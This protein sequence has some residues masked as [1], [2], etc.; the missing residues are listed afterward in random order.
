MGLNRGVHPLVPSHGS[1]GAS[2]DLAPLAHIALVLIGEGQVISERVI[3][4]DWFDRRI[5]QARTGASA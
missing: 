2:G 4:P 5:A 3:D 1:V